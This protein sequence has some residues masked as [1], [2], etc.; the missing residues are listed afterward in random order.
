MQTLLMLRP[1]PYRRV[2]HVTAFDVRSQQSEATNTEQRNKEQEK[3]DMSGDVE[4]QGSDFELTESSSFES[5][6]A[7]SSNSERT[8]RTM[9]ASNVIVSN[10]TTLFSPIDRNDADQGK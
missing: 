8:A 3:E 9:V 5:P 6:I 4:Q 1:L 2:H 7:P 10:H